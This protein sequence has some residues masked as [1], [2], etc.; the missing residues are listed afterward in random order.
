MKK[1][2]GDMKILGGE[3][4]RGKDFQNERWGTQLLKLNLAIKKGKTG[5]FQRQISINFS[6]NLPAAAQ[7]PTFLDIYCAY[8]T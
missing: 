5:D 8:H 4:K 6:K 7:D 2:E 1:G 3:T